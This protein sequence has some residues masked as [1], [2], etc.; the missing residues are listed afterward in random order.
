M[1][2]PSNVFVIFSN[3]NTNTNTNVEIEDEQ[4]NIDIFTDSGRGSV[5]VLLLE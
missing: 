1:F 4:L 2:C 3:T 5:Q